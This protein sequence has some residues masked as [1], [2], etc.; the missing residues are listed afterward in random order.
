VGPRAVLDAVAKRKIPRNKSFENVSQF[1]YFERTL[2]IQNC[3]LEETKSGLNSRC[4]YYRS[5]QDILSSRLVCRNSKFKIPTTVFY[6]LFVRCE[7]W[8]DSSVGIVLGYRLDDRGSRIRVPAGARNFSL[9]HR[10]HNGSGT[11]PA[12]Y[13]TGTRGSFPVDKAAGE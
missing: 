6:L 4:A 9:H 11:H 10:V 1:K 8:S 2:T 3:I 13:P 5:V 7:I 12:S